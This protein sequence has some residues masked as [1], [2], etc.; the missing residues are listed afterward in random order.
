MKATRWDETFFGSER[1]SLQDPSLPGSGESLFSLL[2]K[3]ESQLKKNHKDGSPFE[4]GS[5][6]LAKTK[7]LKR[8]TPRYLSRYIE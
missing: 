6:E 7:D 1:V 8:S 3:F 2:L 5:G 4:L